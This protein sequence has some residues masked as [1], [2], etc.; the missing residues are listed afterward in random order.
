MKNV[1]SQIPE[2]AKEKTTLVLAT[3]ISTSGSTPQKAGALALFDSSG[4]KAGTI[5]GGYLE[6]KV[7]ELAI[8]AS[9]NGNSG[10]YN[11]EL[12]KSIEHK[13]EAICGGRVRVLIESGVAKYIPLVRLVENSMKQRKPIVILTEISAISDNSLQI[14]RSVLS[15]ADTE[16]PSSEL[17][18]RISPDLI[19]IFDDSPLGSFMVIDSGNQEK[20]GRDIQLLESLFPLP[21]LIIAGA[22]HI[23]KALSHLGKMIDFEVI[24]IDDRPEFANPVNIPDADHL[25]VE[26]IGKAISRLKPGNDTYVVIV[27][28]GHNDDAEALKS[29]IGTG[30][31]YV[32]MIGS[33]TKVEKMQRNFI[34]NGW[35]TE[36]QWKAIHTPVGIGIN[37][38]SVEEIAVSIAA[39]L[40]MVRNA[41]YK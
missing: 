9:R 41:V 23:G 20:P 31:F 13:S 25:I 39:E 28:R 40:I 17:L 36:D 5:G 3:V 37:A 27:T 30:A 34:E 32:G 1:Y 18:K 2:I 16:N 33:R 8:E 15:K 22:G 26:D 24:V 14:R 6:G 12:D 35:A 10:I 21:L 7:T 11:F 38:K 19:R 29:S 4:L